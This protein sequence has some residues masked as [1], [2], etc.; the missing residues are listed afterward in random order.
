MNK[1][2]HCQ[3]ILME[4]LL[5]NILINFN[6]FWIGSIAREAK[7]HWTADFGTWFDSTTNWKWY[8]GV[9]KRYSSGDFPLNFVCNFVIFIKCYLVSF[10]SKPKKSS[11]PVLRKSDSSDNGQ[12]ANLIRRRNS[13]LY[14]LRRDFRGWQGTH[15][16]HCILHDILMTE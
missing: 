14:E 2:L 13:R 15:E 1:R 5:K 11:S 3:L 16:Q 6:L 9:S 4:Y 8:D 12:W 7:S 10:W